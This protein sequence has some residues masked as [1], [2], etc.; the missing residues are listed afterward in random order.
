MTAG[1]AARHSLYSRLEEVLGTEDAD[2]LMTHLPRDPNDTVATKSDID[3]LEVRFDR[4]EA[5][6]DQ[7]FTTIID[8]QTFYART[9]VWSIVG[10][11]SI[12]ALLVTFFG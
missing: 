12:F 9:T 6:F 2:T 4:L 8:Q 1:D 11:T 5:R 3:R 7:L 10:L